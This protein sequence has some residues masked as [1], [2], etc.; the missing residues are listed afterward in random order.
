MLRRRDRANSL[1]RDLIIII[2]IPKTLCIFAS[3]NKPTIFGKTF[4]QTYPTAVKG[5]CGGIV[6]C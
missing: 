1:M 2:G 6:S 4:H 5:H 3:S